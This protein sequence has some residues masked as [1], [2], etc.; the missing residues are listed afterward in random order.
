MGK[1]NEENKGNGQRFFFLRLW[2]SLHQ[3]LKAQMNNRVV[4]IFQLSSRTYT[5]MQ[6]HTETTRVTPLLHSGM[7]FLLTL[8]KEECEDLSGLKNREG[9]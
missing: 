2:P 9:A 3:S 8:E 7:N 6:A 5:Y 4:F 1:N